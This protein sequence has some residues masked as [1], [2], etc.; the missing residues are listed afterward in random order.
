MKST[1]GEEIINEALLTS[2]A[3][4]YCD[5]YEPEN[6]I[7]CCKWAY[8]VLKSNTDESSFELANVF[9]RAKKMINPDYS[10]DDDFK[11]N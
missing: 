2:V 8:K 7:M 1:Y 10:Q 5:L 9:L 6:A 11:E 3:A 4:A